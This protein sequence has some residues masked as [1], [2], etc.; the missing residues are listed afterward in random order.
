MYPIKAFTIPGTT[1]NKVSKIAVLQK[2]Q[3]ENSVNDL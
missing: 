2:L 3:S 1:Y